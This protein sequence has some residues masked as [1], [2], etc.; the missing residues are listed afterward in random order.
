MQLSWNIQT[1]SPYFFHS[2][3]DIR[4][5][6]SCPAMSD[7]EMTI[8]TFQ[9]FDPTHT[10]YQWMKISHLTSKEADSIVFTLENTCSQLIKNK[11]SQYLSVLFDI[12]KYWPNMEQNRRIFL[13]IFSKFSVK[14]FFWPIWRITFVFIWI[15][16]CLTP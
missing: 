13:L 3:V 9:D 12:V 5:Q 7:S 1:L 6:L 8:S 15:G 10:N 11:K 4:W 2:D 14:D 16:Q